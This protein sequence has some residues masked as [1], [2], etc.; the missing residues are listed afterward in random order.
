MHRFAVVRAFLRLAV[1]LAVC[2]LFV[3]AA[4]SSTP[5]EQCIPGTEHCSPVG[6][7]STVVVVG[8][9][10]GS[11]RILNSLLPFP[12]SNPASS[13]LGIDC[14]VGVSNPTH[15]TC[16]DDFVPVVRNPASNQYVQLEAIANSGSVFAGWFSGC[17][18]I[19]NIGLGIGNGC[20]I[21]YS[22]A[23]VGITYT[24]TAQ[25]NLVTATTCS[26]PVVIQDQFDSD[27]GWTATATTSGGSPT[28]SVTFQAAG[29]NPGGYRQMQHVFAGASAIAVYHSYG[30]TT[31]NP[32]TQGAIDHINYFED[33]IELNPPFAGCCR[34]HR[35]QH[36]AGRNPVQHH[37]PAAVG[38]VHE[39]RMGD[40][41]A[42]EPDRR[43]LLRCR[44]LG[45][46]WPSHVRLLP[47]QHHQRAAAATITHGIDN[48]RVEICR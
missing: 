3:T 4:C 37:P 22:A 5:E 43:G 26:N 36:D 15:T 39:H 18:E 31:Y 46:G 33:Q 11:G 2:S 45:D 30:T 38:R 27:A 17:S 10:T 34:R 29:G 13:D 48:W 44:L 24:V 20:V 47:E 14:D 19:V 25:F 21:Q 40:D 23:G 28:Q 16:Q 41:V 42:A 7:H 32:S 12:P 1:M 6:D 9:G 8:A 35:V